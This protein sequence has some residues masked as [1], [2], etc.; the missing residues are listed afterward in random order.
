MR[1]VKAEWTSRRPGASTFNPAMTFHGRICQC[2]G[3]MVPPSTSFPFFLSVDMHDTDY[4]V[5]R[6]IQ[7]AAVQKLILNILQQLRAMLH[8]YNRYL[9]TFLSLRSWANPCGV[10]RQLLYGD[11]C[12][13]EAC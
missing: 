10:L 1:Y 3:A 12:E 11:P 4:L 13:Q 7:I 8:E 2:L 5:Q 6:K 9:Q